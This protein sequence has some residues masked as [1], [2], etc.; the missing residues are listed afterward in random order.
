MQGQQIYILKMQH[1]K[2]Q[3]DLEELQVCLYFII[4]VQNI[5]NLNDLFED[6]N[7]S[8]EF[9]DNFIKKDQKFS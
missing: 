6:F 3:T 2:I 5:Q 7:F 1:E 9:A 8:L 4:R